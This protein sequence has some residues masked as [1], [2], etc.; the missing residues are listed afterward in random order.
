MYIYIYTYTYGRY[1]QC[2]L[3]KLRFFPIFV[4]DARDASN[5]G[6]V[7]RAVNRWITSVYDC[8]ASAGWS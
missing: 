3:T 2:L 7:V 5:H 4:S 1:L 8:Q 6:A